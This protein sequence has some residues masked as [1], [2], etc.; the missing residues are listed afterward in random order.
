M[1]I[2]NKTIVVTHVTNNNVLSFKSVA[3]LLPMPLSPFA[4]SEINNAPIEITKP[5][6]GII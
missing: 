6:I 4:A 1:P 3:A 5:I 2:T